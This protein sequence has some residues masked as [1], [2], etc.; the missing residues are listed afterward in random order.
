MISS[1]RIPEV[2]PEVCWSNSCCVTRRSRSILR[3]RSFETRNFFKFNEQL[4]RHQLTQEMNYTN[5]VVR[6]FPAALSVREFAVS[7]K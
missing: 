7:A 2:R 3:T 4:G 5:R 6:E 1:S